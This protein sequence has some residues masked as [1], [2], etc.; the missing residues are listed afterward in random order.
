M[1]LVLPLMS[2][3]VDVDDL[4]RVEDRVSSVVVEHFLL[5][6]EELIVLKGLFHANLLL[7]RAQCLEL[8]AQFEVLALPAEASLGLADLAHRSG[9]V[10][11]GLVALI[12]L[13]DLEGI[14][15]DVLI[16]P[17]KVHGEGRPFALDFLILLQSRLA[18]MRQTSGESGTDLL[19]TEAR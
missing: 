10:L 9:S 13:L 12:L 1:I 15:I 4:E 16:R 3:A 18:N 14:R 17:S 6:H 19:L 2:L 8:E 11:R 5:P 7:Q